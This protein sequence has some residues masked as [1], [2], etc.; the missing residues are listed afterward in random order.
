MHTGATPPKHPAALSIEIE[1]S[2]AATLR[3]E[4]RRRD[5]SVAR[6]AL[7]LLGAIASDGLVTAVL[8]DDP[9][10]PARRGPGRPRSTNP[11]T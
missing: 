6:L 10:S 11:S 3:P 4:A 9:P 1:H 8:D 2:L 7:D 5:V